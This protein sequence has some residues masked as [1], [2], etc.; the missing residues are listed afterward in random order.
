MGETVYEKDKKL[1]KYCCQKCGYE[2]ET[3]GELP[4]HCPKCGH[5]SVKEKSWCTN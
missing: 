1:K 2:D 5:I 4:V 3:K